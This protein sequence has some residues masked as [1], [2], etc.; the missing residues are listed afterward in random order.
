M[1]Y[2]CVREESDLKFPFLLWCL[3]HFGQHSFNKEQSRSKARDID[4]R[5]ANPCCIRLPKNQLGKD[6]T[7]EPTQGLSSYVDGPV[8]PYIICSKSMTMIFLR[9]R[10]KAN[11]TR[12]TEKLIQDGQTTHPKKSKIQCWKVGLA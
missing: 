6:K 9:G 12:K 7:R 1:F 3:K 4:L 11:S 8:S 5:A 10:R 2:E